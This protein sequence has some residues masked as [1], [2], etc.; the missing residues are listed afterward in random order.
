MACEKKNWMRTG[1][2]SSHGLMHLRKRTATEPYGRA[3]TSRETAMT[4]PFL[5]SQM[6][7]RYPRIWGVVLI[8]VG[9]WLA[10][11]QIYDPLHAAEQH[12]K[13]VWILSELIALAVIGPAYGVLLLLFGRWPIRW[14]AFNPENLNW[15]NTLSL[16]FFAASGVAAIF[17]VIGSLE[18][19][20]YVVKHGW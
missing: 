19:Q 9:L 15:K 3:F 7:T 2:K 16:V 5:E 4:N 11:W 6:A 14:F 20:G 1:G 12:R 8:A 10:K 17:Y 18:S 13:E